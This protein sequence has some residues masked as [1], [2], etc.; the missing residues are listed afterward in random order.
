MSKKFIKFP[1]IRQ[2]KDAIKEITVKEHYVNIDGMPVLKFQGTVKLHGTNGAVVQQPS[3]ERTVQSRNRILSIKSDNAGFAAF[4]HGKAK[5]F[6]SIF[7]NILKEED[8][9]IAVFGEWCGEGI[10]KGVGISTLEKMFV[11]FAIRAR[12]SEENARWIPV[13]NL[14]LNQEHKENNIHL[15]TE[16]PTYDIDIDMSN[17]KTSQQKLVE[18]TEQ[19]EKEC[20]VA[21]EFQVEN[22]TGEGAVWICKTS[23]YESSDFWFKVKGEKHSVSKVKSLASVDPEKIKNVQEFT[24]MSVTENRCLQGLDFLREKGVEKPSVKD[25]GIFLSWLVNDILEEEVDS[26][27]E[28]GLCAKDVNKTIS[29]I[30]RKWFFKWLEEN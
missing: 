18:I 15:I 28:S 11:I 25:T 19:I 6:D 13:E 7:E 27:V 21:R 30:G 23:G 24:D 10:Q 16:F 1:K 17:P 29:T 4:V 14:S 12:K 5:Y 2:F 20:P 26:L 8:E 9:A 22:G 3:G